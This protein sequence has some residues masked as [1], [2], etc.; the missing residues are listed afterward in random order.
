MVFFYKMLL[1]QMRYKF[2]FKYDFYQENE[3]MI[4]QKKKQKTNKLSKTKHRKKKINLTGK[5]RLTNARQ[6]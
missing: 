5:A 6:K 2:F 3:Y 1:I 4:S